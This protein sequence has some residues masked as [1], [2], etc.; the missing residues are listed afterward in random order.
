MAPALH[1]TGSDDVLSAWANGWMTETGYR[2][3]LRDGA[4]H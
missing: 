4:L 2:H 3:L 1:A